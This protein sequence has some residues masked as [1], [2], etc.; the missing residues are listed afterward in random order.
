MERVCAGF[1]CEKGEAFVA[2]V[3]VLI[4]SVLVWIGDVEVIQLLVSPMTEKPMETRSFS[5]RCRDFVRS[6][7]GGTER[8]SV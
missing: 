4:G 2:C 1:C 6:V 3:V 8:F 7:S 5:L